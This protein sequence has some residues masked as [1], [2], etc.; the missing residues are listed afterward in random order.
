MK[1]II[2]IMRVMKSKFFR[3]VRFTSVLG[4]PKNITLTDKIKPKCADCTT[5]KKLS[6]MEKIS[7]TISFIIC[8]V[9]GKNFWL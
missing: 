2:K 4:K 6:K 8:K 7:A 5:G 9:G 1:K 3:R